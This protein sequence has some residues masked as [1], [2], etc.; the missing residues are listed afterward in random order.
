MSRSE[1]GWNMPAQ[2]SKIDTGLGMPDAAIDQEVKSWRE[3]FARVLAYALDQA[4]AADPDEA[5]LAGG[6]WYH[7]HIE[8][9][10]CPFAQW[11]VDDGIATPGKADGCD[12]VLMPYQGSYTQACT[13]ALALRLAAPEVASTPVR[14]GERPDPDYRERLQ[15][16]RQR[17]VANAADDR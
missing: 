11:L 17:G 9:A 6:G 12:T 16:I 1:M 7:I 15:R 2:P 4:C 10:G 5:L 8:P 13:L 3:D 14:G